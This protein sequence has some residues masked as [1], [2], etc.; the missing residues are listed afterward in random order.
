MPNKAMHSYV[1]GTFLLLTVPSLLYGAFVIASRN[2]IFG[3]SPELISFMIR[4]PL[5]FMVVEHSP[6]ASARVFS[7]IE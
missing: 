2:A 4:S 6:H 1:L 5:D 7:S 3:N